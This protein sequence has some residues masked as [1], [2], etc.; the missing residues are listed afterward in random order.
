MFAV[1]LIIRP[2]FRFSSYGK[3]GSCWASVSDPYPDPDSIRSEDPYPDRIRIQ[4]GHWIRIWIQEGKNDP[5]K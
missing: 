1:Q 4:S 2:Y 5:Q 3:K